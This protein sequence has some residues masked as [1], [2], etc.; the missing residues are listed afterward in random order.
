MVM[1]LT[2]IIPPKAD[3]WASLGGT[4]AGIKALQTI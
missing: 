1:D 3:M 2:D 4:N